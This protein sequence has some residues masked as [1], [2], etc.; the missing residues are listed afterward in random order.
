MSTSK[1]AV[2]KR[3]GRVI[4]PNGVPVTE[5]RVLK[6]RMRGNSHVRFGSGGGA[7]DRPTDRNLSRRPP[8]GRPAA[9]APIVSPLLSVI[10]F[11]LKTWER[12]Q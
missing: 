3:R 10:E 11:M 5:T 12:T 2:A 6:S 7:G 8:F 9:Q 4:A 1:R